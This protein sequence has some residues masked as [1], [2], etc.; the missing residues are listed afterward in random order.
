LPVKEFCIFAANYLWQ[1]TGEK[2]VIV[3]RLE[4]GREFN[5][6]LR[7]DLVGRNRR[8]SD[9]KRVRGYLVWERDFPRTA[10]LKI[11]RKELA[12]QIRGSTDATAVAQL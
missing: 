9:F 12:E 1:A 7:R 6:A 11:K 8:L 10:S 2:L 3:L 4:P 5:D